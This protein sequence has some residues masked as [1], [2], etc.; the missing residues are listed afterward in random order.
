MADP[1]KFSIMTFQRKPGL[2][3]ASITRT[4]RRPCIASRTNG[5]DI[6]SIVTP[7]DSG[8]E[9]AAGEAAKAVIKK[10]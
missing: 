6:L 2:W 3:R 9:D 5:K 10:L 7:A 1:A 8:S 4:D